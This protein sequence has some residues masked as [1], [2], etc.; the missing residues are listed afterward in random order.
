M[1]SGGAASTSVFT[2]NDMTFGLFPPAST[3]HERP[4]QAVKKAA[5]LVDETGSTNNGRAYT[6]DDE[7]GPCYTGAG[8]CLASVKV[9]FVQ[10]SATFTRSQCVNGPALARQLNLTLATHA[11]PEDS[12]CH[13]TEGCTAE[14]ADGAVIAT[15]P[16]VPT[17]EQGEQLPRP[18]ASASPTRRFT[19]SAL[20]SPFLL[21]ADSRPHLLQLREQSSC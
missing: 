11:S 2:Q 20:S 6:A 14:N 9:G 7:L 8:G 1:M 5:E 13:Q 19:L 17:L 12:L 4:L 15:I 16:K 3:Y 21:I 18:L 10:S